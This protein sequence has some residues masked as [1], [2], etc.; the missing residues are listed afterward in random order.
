M[1]ELKHVHDTVYIAVKL[2]LRLTSLISAHRLGDKNHGSRADDVMLLCAIFVGQHE[3][4]PMTASKLAQYVGIP[5]PTVV[6]KLQA[7]KAAGLVAIS[8]AGHVITLELP[9]LNVDWQY[10]SAAVTAIKDAATKLS[11]MDA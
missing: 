7:M 4:R 5:R 11:K 9:D 1:P 2:M 6:R 3:N 10:V 8:A